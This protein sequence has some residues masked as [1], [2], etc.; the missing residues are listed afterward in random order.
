VFQAAAE[1]GEFGD[2]E[3]VSPAVGDQEGLVEFG[4]AGELAGRFVDEDLFAACGGEGVVL[5]AGVLVAGET[6]P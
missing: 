2:H 6:R 1:P 5:G 4:A 3:L